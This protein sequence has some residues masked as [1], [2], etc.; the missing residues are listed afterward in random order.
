MNRRPHILVTEALGPRGLGWLLQQAEVDAHDLLSAEALPGLVGQ[1]DAVIIRSAHRLTRELLLAGQP[2]LRVVARAGAGVD[3]VDL[4]AATE[5][6]V[7]VINAPGANAVAAAEHAMGL[8][9]AVSRNIVAG[10]QHVGQGGWD[11]A[12]YMGQELSRKRLGIVGLGRVG[13]HVARIAHGFEMEVSAYDPYLSDD[14]FT[15]CRVTRIGRIE[16]LL[17]CSDVLTLHTPKTGPRLD[18]A[19]LLELP[20]GAIV[21]NAARGGLVDEM[22][23]ASLLQEGRLGGYGVDVFESEPPSSESPLF[24]SPGVVMTPHLGG[25]THEAMAEV[26]LRT[27]Q[28][29]MAALEGLTP[30]NIVNVPIPELDHQSIQKLD[31]ACRV[32]GRLFAR[33]ARDPRA[34]MVMSLTGLSSSVVPWLRQA[35]LAGYLNGLVDGEV[36]TVNAL[37]RAEQQGLRLLV[38]EPLCPPDAEPSL[39]LRWEGREGTATGVALRGEQLVLK[40]LSGTHVDFP[41]ADCVLVTQHQDAPGVVGRVGTLVGCHGVNIGRLALGRSR[42]GNRAIMMMSLDDHPPDTLLEEIREVAGIEDVFVC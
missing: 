3:N 41:W 34:T 4:D 31:Y 24:R 38:E 42:E 37:I 26:G 7:A 11:R 36:N 33:L 20:P 27:A 39:E 13:R 32:L 9:L 21:I 1:Y 5:L 25:S 2:R 15:R 28:G 12:R 35:I 10:H 22:A 17:A 40:R 16:D 19:R 18:T 14:V 30:W 8:M 29:V 23:V 6:G